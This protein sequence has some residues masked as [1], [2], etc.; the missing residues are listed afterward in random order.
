MGG[1]LPGQPTGLS[2]TIGMT[3]RGCNV[4]FRL[5][6]DRN[7]I[8]RVFIV[9][10]DPTR[11]MRGG[12]WRSAHKFAQIIRL[13]TIL[14]KIEAIDYNFFENN[15]SCASILRGVVEEKSSGTPLT[16]Q[17]LDSGLRQWLA[18]KG[19]ET[20]EDIEE[21][22]KLVGGSLAEGLFVLLCCLPRRYGVGRPRLRK[23]SV[24]RGPKYSKELFMAV[25]KLREEKVK[26]NFNCPNIDED[27]HDKVPDVTRI[28]RD[29]ELE[30]DPEESEDKPARMM[31]FSVDITDELKIEIAEDYE[32]DRD[33]LEEKG[34]TF[35][36]PE[37]AVPT[38]RPGY[39][40]RK[41]RL[42]SAR[43]QP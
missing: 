5:M 32:I 17:L 26:K 27:D 39:E 29:E 16:I 42:V 21:L 8:Q 9:I 40:G 30:D 37:L 36:R 43:K 31:E 34:G 10:P 15:S 2:P 6:L 12:N 11:L 35:Q 25:K 4:A 28:E 18:R 7:N 13:A 3:L 20:D 24:I 38:T 14:T 19:F 23:K 1:C 33:R 22:V 41:R